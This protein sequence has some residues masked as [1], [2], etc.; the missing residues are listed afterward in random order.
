MDAEF[1]KERDSR[2]AALFRDKPEMVT[3]FPEWML[4]RQ[5]IEAYRAMSRLAIVEIA[6]RDSVAAAVQAVC[7]NAYTDLL[8]VY[9]YT[10]SEHGPWQS[11]VEAV[12]RMSGRLPEVRVH[13][14][15][16]LGSPEFWRALNGRFISDLIACFGRYTP[17]TGCHLYL[18][19]VRIPL[20]RMLGN[21]PIIGGERE[22]HSGKIKVNQCAPALDFYVR[23]LARFQIRLHLPLAKVTEGEQIERI[24]GMSWQRGEDQL[25]CCLSGN[26]NRCQGGTGVS[27][28]DVMDFFQAFAGPCAEEIISTYLENRVPGHTEIAERALAT[29]RS[30]K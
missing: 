27:E 4:P 13:P 5:W 10:G 18:H 8:P 21:V 11:V 12:D 17:C 19:G 9:V 24:L 26:Y 3:D 29:C 28:T 15:V 14:L 2:L 23:F 30:T 1:Y 25:G 7:E 6:G 22:S 16:V 20:A